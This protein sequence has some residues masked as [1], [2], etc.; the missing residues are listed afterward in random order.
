MSA[1]AVL[2]ALAA[3]ALAGAPGRVRRRAGRGARHR[4]PAARA[5][6]PGGPGQLPD[7]RLGPV[8][9]TNRRIYKFNAQFDE[10]VFLPA[11]EAYEYV[12]PDFIENG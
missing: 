12:T 6:A 2:R 7:R 9:G 10:W 1:V 8:G 4:T 3:L 11:V 5:R